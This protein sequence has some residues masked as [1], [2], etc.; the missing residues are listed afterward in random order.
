MTQQT[1][2]HITADSKFS[3]WKSILLF[4]QFKRLLYW[5]TW[6]DIKVRF[7]NVYEGIFTAVAQPLLMMVV[8]I[9][10]FD[11]IV[12]VPTGDVPYALFI[13][14]GLAP[15]MLFI[16]IVNATARSINA[17]APLVG[18]VYFPRL[19]IAVSS[20][21]IPV[22]D[23]LI[24]LL[25]LLVALPIYNFPLSPN[26]AIIP[27]II[28]F[29]SLLAFSIGIC[30]SIISIKS[31]SMLQMLPVLLQIWLFVSPILYPI[32]QVPSHIINWYAINP[33]VGIIQGFRYSLLPGHSPFN[34]SWLLSSI[35]WILFLFPAAI[36]RF[37]VT[38]RTIVDRM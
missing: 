12:R 8:Y 13:I 22:I 25:L 35:L 15:W 5:L 23:F 21:S 11:Y 29:I 31:P 1:T 4:W 28:I 10:A 27:I 32:N 19:V 36:W 2:I 33:L 26:L 37:S 6:R 18:K 34:L 3:F 16:N 14:T 7:Q 38:E 24:L 20:N 9:F 30:F 17:N